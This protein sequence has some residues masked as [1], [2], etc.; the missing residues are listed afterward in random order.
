MPGQKLFNPEVSMVYPTQMKP[1]ATEGWTEFMNSPLKKK[2]K[3]QN[4]HWSL[5][6]H[7]KDNNI[8]FY[9]LTHIFLHLD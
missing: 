7:E 1:L 8:C 3:S 6:Y 5:K 4:Y 9:I 2:N